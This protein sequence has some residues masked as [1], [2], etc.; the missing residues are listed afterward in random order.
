MTLTEIPYESDVDYVWFGADVYHGDVVIRD[1]LLDRN[2]IFECDEQG[3]L[4]SGNKYQATFSFVPDEEGAITIDVYAHRQY[5][6]TF[7]DAQIYVNPAP[8]S[9]TSDQTGNSDASGNNGNTG[10]P[11]FEIILIICAFALVLFW[12]R[13]K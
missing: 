7:A 4:I 3:T 2:M 1:N 13:K 6:V 8:E 11:G 12:K 10:I 5:D 9:E